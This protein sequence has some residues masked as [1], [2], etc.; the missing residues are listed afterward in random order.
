MK[1]EIGLATSSAQT[2]ARGFRN[3]ESR[4]AGYW[5]TPSRQNG[6]NLI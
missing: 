5:S 2:F 6:R 1:Q 4:R 3:A